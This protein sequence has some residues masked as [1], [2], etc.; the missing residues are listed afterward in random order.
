MLIA[1]EFL[2]IKLLQ[3]ISPHNQTVELILCDF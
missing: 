3:A 2:T 1:I